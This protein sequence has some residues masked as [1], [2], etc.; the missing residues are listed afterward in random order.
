MARPRKKDRHLPPCIYLRHGA[1]WHVKRGKWTRLGSTLAAALEAYARIVEGAGSGMSA[2]IDAGSPR[3]GRNSRREL[4]AIQSA[5]PSQN[6]VQRLHPRI[7][8]SAGHAALE[9]GHD[10]R[11][12][13]CNLCLTVLRQVYEYAVGEVLDVNPL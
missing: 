10:R 1:Y 3:C 6:G 13:T 11:P 12:V 5:A 7:H 2:F 4:E 9:A 8:S